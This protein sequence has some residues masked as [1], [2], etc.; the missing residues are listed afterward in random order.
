MRAWY[1]SYYLLCSL[2]L[3]VLQSLRENGG[4]YLS[5]KTLRAS[6]EQFL[7][8]HLLMP[9]NAGRPFFFLLK[10]YYLYVEEHKVYV[11]ECR[12]PR[13][14]ETSDPPGAEVKG[15]CELSYKGAGNQTP[16]LCKSIDSSLVPPVT[17]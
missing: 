5:L 1:P 2:Q 7:G 11:C 15:S 17:S 14:A 12:C 3:L 6:Q 13:R 4:A 16:V 9:P 8:T 10:F